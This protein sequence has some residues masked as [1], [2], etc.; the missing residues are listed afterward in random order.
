MSGADGT[1]AR[2]PGVLVVLEGV[3]GSGTTTQ[4]DEIV[5]H[6]AERRVPHHRTRQPSGGPV[7]ML[8]RLALSRR[9]GQG[10]AFHDAAQEE[11]PRAVGLDEHTMALLFAAD[12]TDHL[13][14]EILPN[15]RRGKVVVCDRYVLSSLAYQGLTAGDDWV[16][17]LNRHAYTPDLTLYLDLPVERAV[18]RMAASRWTKDLYEEDAVLRRVRDRYRA[19]IDARHDV[20]G[21]VTVVDAARPRD[22]VAA[23]VRA[24]V[25]AL[26]RA[27]GIGPEPQQELPL[28]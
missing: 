3:D 1:P 17:A 18:E 24:R 7:G 10:Y 26:L 16:A 14:A 20:V 2:L 8:I 23:E 22:A 5:R 21:E 11:A 27:R 25:D 4:G 6:L 13:H 15:L 19:V 12:R 9:L 28:R